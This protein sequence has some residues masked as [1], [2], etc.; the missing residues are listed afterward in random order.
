MSESYAS[1]KQAITIATVTG[2]ASSAT[3]IMGLVI[4]GLK[5]SDNHHT[6]GI[7]WRDIGVL[8]SLGAMLGA[9]WSV[10]GRPWFNRM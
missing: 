7:D 9:Q 2:I 6:R 5:D 4:S 8:G 1:I 3:V 10:T